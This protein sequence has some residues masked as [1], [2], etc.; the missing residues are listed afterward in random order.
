[1][2]NGVMD[3]AFISAIDF[4]ANGDVVLERNDYAK[5]IVL[6]ASTGNIWRVGPTHGYVARSLTN[7]VKQLYVYD[8]LWKVVI[9]EMHFGNYRE[10]RSHK[11]M[12][13]FWKKSY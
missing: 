10:D 11:N 9:P 7:L 8:H 3:L 5:D 6:I 1:M 12:L 2:P 4:N 13:L